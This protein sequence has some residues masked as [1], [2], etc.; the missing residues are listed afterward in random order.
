MQSPTSVLVRT[1]AIDQELG[2]IAGR[3]RIHLDNIEL[4]ERKA[5]V[6]Y[7]LR[8][9]IDPDDDVRPFL[10]WL[11]HIEIEDDAGTEYFSNSGAYDGD[12]NETQGSRDMQPAPPPDATQLTLIVLDAPEKG[13][14]TEVGRVTVEL[15]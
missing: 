3:R 8:P 15:S 14:P 13:R 11:W 5:F 9:G 7:R 12:A 2:P 1:I 4:Y 10:G 6:N